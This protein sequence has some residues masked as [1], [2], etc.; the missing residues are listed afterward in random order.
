ML[1]LVAI[2]KPLLVTLAAIVADRIFGEPHYHPLV[3][4]GN[5]ANS[6][7]RR[8][9]VREGIGVGKG[10]VAL[11]LVVV[12]PV[13][14][15]ALIDHQLSFS[16]LPSILFDIVVLWFV[17]G[18]QSLKEHARAVATPLQQGNLSEARAQLAM[19]VSR[20]TKGMDAEKIAGSTVESVLEN[21]HDSLFASI[22]WY[23]LLGPAGALLHRLVNTLDAMWGY[24]TNR[25]EQFGKSAARLDDV[26]GYLPARLTAVGYAVAGATQFAF[27]C[28]FEQAPI[29]PSPNAGVVMA[30]GAGAMGTRIGGPTVYQGELK[31]KPWLG[32]GE[33]P[34][35][36]DIE[37]SISL[38]ERSLRLWLILLLMMAQLKWMLSG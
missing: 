11:L 23:V 15:I 3:W 34:A 9:N 32:Q 29:H 7:E 20:D 19:I 25:F 37:R 21:G 13:A 27:R 12:P 22:F 4:F 31:D 36:T 28:W 2:F 35:A 8:L 1:S 30:A 18:W 10:V 26:L 5:V 33:N 38:I 16:L 14:I 6:V 17:I 24:R